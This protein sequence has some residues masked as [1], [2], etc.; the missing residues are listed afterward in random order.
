MEDNEEDLS[1]FDDMID[2]TGGDTT[3]LT[4]INID[5]EEDDDIDDNF[6]IQEFEDEEDPDYQPT[7]PSYKENTLIN[8][9]LALK[10]IKNHT[11]QFENEEGKIEDIDFYDLPKN[12]Q[13]NIINSTD[14]DINFDLED[15]E[16]EAINFMRENNVSFEEAIDYF[17][18]EAI[19]EYINSQNI[20][21]IEV[22]QYTDEQ[23]F[24]IDLK[25]RYENLTDD[26]ITIEIEKQLEHPDLFKKKIDKL[27][28]DYKE[29]EVTQLQAAKQQQESTDTQRYEELQTNLITVAEAVQDIGGLDLDIDDKNDILTYILEK[30]INGTS[31][32]IRSLDSPEKLFELAWYATKGKEAFNILHDYYKKQIDSVRKTSYEKG[33]DE[34]KGKQP[35]TDRKKFVRDQPTKPVNGQG[36]IRSIDDF[37]LDLD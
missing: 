1:I 32:F 2:E 8:D 33:R 36:K 11:V 25:A 6:E 5:S 35:E 15:N 23:L 30:D 9:I 37:D 31:Q 20:A 22:D 26:E 27:R 18:R 4:P 34:A 28:T 17:K 21:G 24:A 19:E 12:E 10:G 14:K 13:L 3:G 16:V 7:V 29:M